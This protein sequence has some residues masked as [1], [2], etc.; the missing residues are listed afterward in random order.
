M[1]ANPKFIPAKSRRVVDGEQVR[2]GCWDQVV[3]AARGVIEAGPLA[4]WRWEAREEIREDYKKYSKSWHSE[5]GPHRRV[6]SR[7]LV[8]FRP[9]SEEVSISIWTD[10]WRGHWFKR[11]VAVAVAKAA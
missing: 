4:G 9:G 7:D 5:F 2:G 3:I 1:N 6:W 8:F 11:M 10:A